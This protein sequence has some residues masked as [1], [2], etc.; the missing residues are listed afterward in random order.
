MLFL[1]LLLG[2]MLCTAKGNEDAPEGEPVGMTMGVSKSI[3]LP[4]SPDS[5]H[6]LREDGL[7]Q[8]VSQLTK[9]QQEAATWRG[10]VVKWLSQLVQE[11]REVSSGQG[12]VIKLLK[13]MND[14]RAQQL[15]DLRNL[16]RQQSLQVE[17]NQALLLQV[18]R[19][20][21]YLQ[22]LLEQAKISKA[23]PASAG[24]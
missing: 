12:E 14:Q 5:I 8:L 19:I 15:I 22:D 18:S 9:D 10:D 13:A 6:P 11:Q 23:R 2:I 17:N 4:A 24:Q 7:K 3:I 20:S 1:S 16:S 21:T